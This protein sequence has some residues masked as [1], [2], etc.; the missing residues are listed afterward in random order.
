MKIKKIVTVGPVLEPEELRLIIKAL[1]TFSLQEMERTASMPASE[2]R[3][4][5]S[6]EAGLAAGLAF[7]IDAS[8]PKEVKK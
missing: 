3:S 4:L 1:R 5:K 6:F 8:L 2:E 7:R